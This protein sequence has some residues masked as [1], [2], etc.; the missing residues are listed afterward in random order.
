MNTNRLLRRQAFTLIELL[1]VIC[2]LSL[3]AAILFPVFGRVREKGRQ[4]ACASNV[5]SLGMGFLQYSQDYD[6]KYPPGLDNGS[7]I[8]LVT[9]W[10]GQIFSYVKNDAIFACPSDLVRPAGT[11][12]SPLT[13]P[14]VLVSYAYNAV[15]PEQAASIGV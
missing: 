1:V 13:P 2:I 7:T 4:T 8:G 3:L 15:L 6:E 10:G 11:V 5:K 14:E 12:T 9:G